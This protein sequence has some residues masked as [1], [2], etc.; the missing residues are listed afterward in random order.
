MTKNNQFVC[1]LYIL[2]NILGLDIIIAAEDVAK[3]ETF[4]FLIN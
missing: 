3:N 2:I 1:L 4:C